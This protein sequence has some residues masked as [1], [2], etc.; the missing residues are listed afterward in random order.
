[1]PSEVQTSESCGAERIGVEVRYHTW[2]VIHLAISRTCVVRSIW[3]TEALSFFAVE[4][5]PFEALDRKFGLELKFEEAEFGLASIEKIGD[6]FM[7][8]TLERARAWDG[9]IE[10]PH[11][12]VAYPAPY[13]QMAPP[14]G[15]RR[16]AVRSP[17]MAV[18]LAAPAIQRAPDTST[19]LPVT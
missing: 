12:K 2:G 14:R 6:S 11:H 17:H 15:G 5:R 1:M 3:T 8:A 18:Q 13:N 4:L 10:G 9:I 7:Q 16:R 19:R